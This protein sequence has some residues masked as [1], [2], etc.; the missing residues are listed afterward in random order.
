ML[1]KVP[2]MKKES[3]E[4]K[5]ET[6]PENINEPLSIQDK[7]EDVIK[8]VQGAQEMPLEAVPSA[9][10]NQEALPEKANE[11][12]VPENEKEIIAPAMDE[13]KESIIEENSESVPV[14]EEEKEV[15]APQEIN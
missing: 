4:E 8:P 12:I 10:E 14:Q 3:D 11:V 6:A 7:P 9:E 2:K 13:N 15:P 5:K 1:L